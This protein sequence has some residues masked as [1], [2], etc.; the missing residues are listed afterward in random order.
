MRILAT[1][2]DG[3][4]IHHPAAPTRRAG[5]RWIAPE[6]PEA[7]DE[8]AELAGRDLVADRIADEVAWLRELRRAVVLARQQVGFAGQQRPV[9]D[10]V[11]EVSPEGA[12][13]PEVIPPRSPQD[14]PLNLAQQTADRN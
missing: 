4:D 11:S 10:Q 12:T 3:V 5:R 6:D 13:Q 2:R 8:D 14:H 7:D 9:L 1:R